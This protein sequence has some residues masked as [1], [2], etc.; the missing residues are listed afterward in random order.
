M[1]RQQHSLKEDIQNHAYETQSLGQT[2]SRCSRVSRLDLA[3]VDFANDGPS[4]AVRK[5]ESKDEHNDEP[6]PGSLR[7]DNFRSVERSDDDHTAR[8]R[9][10]PGDR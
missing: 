7:M 9:K 5:R 2:I 6:L 1:A 4:E 8:E 10:P 3:G